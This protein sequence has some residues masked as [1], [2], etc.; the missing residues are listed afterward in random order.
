[1]VIVDGDNKHMKKLLT[2]ALLTVT[3]AT[4]GCY[5]YEPVAGPVYVAPA[6]VIVVHPY[7]YHY[8]GWGYRHW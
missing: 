8:Y 3:L 5:V 1:M 6:P 4:S 2:L 7:H